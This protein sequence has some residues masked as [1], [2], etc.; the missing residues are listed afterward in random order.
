VATINQIS[1]KSDIKDS[2]TTIY[3]ND[4][5]I[6]IQANQTKLDL[7][8]L[9]AQ[10]NTRV[11]NHVD[12]LS[13]KHK[14]VDVT[15][16]PTPTIP[17]TDAQKAIEKVDQRIANVISSDGT[18]DA[19]VVDAR[20]SSRYGIFPNLKARLDTH[21]NAT[22]PHILFNAKDGK[23]YKYGYQVSATGIPQVISEEVL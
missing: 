4:N 5:A 6:N 9:D 15:F 7:E 13:E 14:A 11:D 20:N 22:M 23:T 12:G 8:S 2:Y 17:E 1:G 21:E 3:N 10:I 18:S 16:E 19:E